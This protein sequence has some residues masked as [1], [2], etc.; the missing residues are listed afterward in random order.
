MTDINKEIIVSRVEMIEIIDGLT[1]ESMEK[2]VGAYADTRTT[3]GDILRANISYGVHAKAKD[4]VRSYDDNRLY[5]HSSLLWVETAINGLHS[6]MI[7]DFRSRLVLESSLFFV[8]DKDIATTINRLVLDS[9]K[10]KEGQQ[11]ELGFVEAVANK[12]IIID[13]SLIKNS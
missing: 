13:L 4:L 7:Q 10:P 12:E 6:F 5:T 9:L 11:T 3:S 2:M 1:I 8:E